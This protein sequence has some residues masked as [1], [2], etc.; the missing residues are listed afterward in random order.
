M[1]E[2][3]SQVPPEPWPP[4]PTSTARLIGWVVALVLLAV[5]YGIL[6]RATFTVNY[7]GANDF[8]VPWYASRAAI[9]EGRDPYGPAVSG[10]IQ[11]VLFGARRAA[12]QHQF[13]FAYPLTLAPLLAPYTL[14]AY[15][16]AQP[17]WQA[18]LH[19]LLIAGLLLW[20]RGWVGPLPRPWLLAALVLWTL[21][22]Y[23]AARA[24]ILGQVAVLVFGALALCLW[25]LRERHDA[26][27][28]LLLAV[29]TVKPQLAYLFVPVMLFLAW[30]SGRRRLLFGFGAGLAGLLALALAIFPA[31]PLAFV[32]RLGEYAR[33]TAP[34]TGID[35]R[36]PLLL[37]TGLL[38]EPAA[39]GMLWV[40]QAGLLALLGGLL[41]W[42]RHAPDWALVASAT[43]S[44]SA[45][46]MPRMGT[47]DQ[48]VLLLPITWLFA[49][50][51]RPLAALG[52]VALFVVPWFV[53]FATLDGDIESVWVRLPTLLLLAALWLVWGWQ[54]RYAAP[55]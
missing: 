34:G 30:H 19:I 47:T 42:Q 27:A 26:L 23:P 12:G 6:L 25:A 9:W 31:W 29:A 35:S 28:G 51:S 43:L 1:S 15:D 33:Y 8:F 53:F 36:G 45:A 49:R 4:A 20:W 52:S 14:L 54:E 37:L 44:V 39:T 32:Q 7:R 48:V 16:W 5:A 38:P 17:L 2:T 24:W 21:A 13:D 10:E 40:V 50:L 55:R 46:L 18:T 3:V 41:W 22:F 11:E